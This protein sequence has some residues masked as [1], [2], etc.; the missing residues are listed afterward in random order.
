MTRARSPA[1]DTIRAAALMG[2]CVV[3]LPFLGQPIEVVLAPPVGTVDTLT[4]IFTSTLFQSKFFLLFSFLFGWGFGAQAAAAAR[5]GRALGP[6][7]GRRLL[8]LGLLGLAHAAFIFVGDIL[9]LY[10]ILGALLWPLR[11]ASTRALS[12]LAAGTVPL[13][14]LALVVLGGLLEQAGPTPALDL[15]GGLGAATAARIAA[16]PGTFGFLLLYQGPLALGAMLCGL[17]AHRAQLLRPDSPARQGLRRSAPAL[18]AV[19][20][21]LSLIMSLAALQ[22]GPLSAA[23]PL[24]NPIASPA[25][26]A[27]WLELLLRLDARL[28]LPAPLA[29]AGASSLT[30]YVLQ[31]VLGGLLFGGHGLGLWGAVGPAALLPLSVAVAL[32]AALL[33]AALAPAG[34]QAP[35]ERLLRWAMGGRGPTPGG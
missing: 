2:I 32:A 35:L 30:T 3:N 7:T 21:F 17:A 1:V 14:G 12:V 15:S 18:G 8:T 22:T 33:C 16:W 19:G 5:E 26:S 20:L 25:L 24:L 11:A 6:R 13:S 23:A 34:Q 10:A 27:A 29:R 9:V 31:G 28:T 4:W